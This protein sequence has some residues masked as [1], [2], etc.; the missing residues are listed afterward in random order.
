MCAGAAPSTATTPEHTQPLYAHHKY[1]YPRLATQ[2]KRPQDA[3]QCKITYPPCLPPP[4]QRCIPS[5]Q[6]GP[7]TTS[8]QRSSGRWRVGRAT[9][10]SVTG[11]PWASVPLRCCSA[12]RHSTPSP[13]LR[14]M[15]KSSTSKSGSYLYIISHVVYWHLTK[16]GFKNKKSI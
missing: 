8:P 9:A 7:R 5:W 12:A 15:P 14:P 1:D 11:G 3:P 10:P 16:I 6:W 4:P 13:C 2:G